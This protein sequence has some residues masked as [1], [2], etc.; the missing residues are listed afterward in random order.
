MKSRYSQIMLMVVINLFIIVSLACSL[1]TTAL[2]TDTPI[3][4]A[5]DMPTVVPL[6]E[7]G[8]VYPASFATFA[9]ASV[10]LPAAYQ[11]GYELPINLSD[12]QG[13]DMVNLSSQQKDLLSQNGFV[14]ARPIPGDDREF[15]SIYREYNPMD[16]PFFATTDAVFHVYHLIL[17][18]IL[19]DLERQE[20]IPRLQAL[21]QSLQ[22]VSMEQ[23]QNLK[24][25]SL[26]EPARRNLAYF[27]VAAQLLG[28]SEP[29]PPEVGELVSA[30]LALIDA[31]SGPA[32]SPIWDRS[33]LVDKPMEDYSQYVPRGHYTISEELGLYFKAMMWY[34]RRTLILKDPFETRRALL[35][36]CAIRQAVTTNGISISQLWSEI[37]D[38]TV[39]IVGKSD[40]LSFYEYGAISDAVFGE[41]PDLQ[42]FA[43]D[44]RLAQFTEMARQ[45]PP[46]QINSM[47]VWVKEDTPQETQGL[48]VMGQ[49][50]T[51]DAYVFGQFLTPKVGTLEHPRT[52]SRALDFFAAMG[53]EEALSILNTM[54]EAQYE[55]FDAQMNKVRQ[56]IASLEFDSWTQNL[57]WSWLYAFQPLMEPK[58]ERYPVFM[59]TQAWTRKDL[60]TALSSWTELKHDTILYAKQTSY[61]AGAAGRD[62][63]PH[64]WVEPNPEV[65][66]RLQALAQ[67][68]YD[69]LDARSLLSK[70][71]RGTLENLID[72]LV[73]M[74]SASERELAGELLADDEYWRI[75]D[76]GFTIRRLTLL[77]L[78]CEVPDEPDACGD[79][80]DD[81]RSALI[82]DVA[83]GISPE[84]APLALEAATGQPTFMYVVLPDEPWRV[85]VGAVFTYY[86]FA[87][88]VNERMT[89]EQWQAQ[90]ESGQNPPPP[91]W[92]QMFFAQ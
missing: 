78:D 51:L 30:E 72:L 40:D 66:A 16:Q 8:E 82:A 19:R 36:T 44:A 24:G 50:F 5:M 61:G 9:S 58:D 54:G 52:L 65:Y 22:V 84:G 79:E 38:P 1:G 87:V 88:P 25:T 47:W 91:D 21:T 90:V 13:I 77:S 7:L 27:S 4:T 57:Y 75:Q 71:S 46:P 45:L 73:F 20:F 37:Y 89:D 59:Q 12:V 85:A 10:S 23:Y 55:N 64:G 69:G 53:S 48:R 41:N 49:R 2:S 35:L 92:V 63:P 26:E 11:G 68:T 74:Q 15:F 34:G 29:I 42:V 83:T 43:D 32:V 31:H 56:E 6:P 62:E 81:K 70:L 60:H 33:E 80:L 76:F 86:E 14:V 39:F 18:K 3:S 67:M 28:L 17:D